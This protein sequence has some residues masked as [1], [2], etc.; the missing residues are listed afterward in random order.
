[1]LGNAIKFTD[2][3]EVVLRVSFLD[4]SP[5]RASLRFDISDT[6]IGIP[7]EA[8]EKIFDPFSQ[9]DGSTTRKYGGTGLGLAICNKLVQLMGGTMGIHSE[10]GKG[11]TFWF[12]ITLEKER[13]ETTGRRK[14]VVSGLKP[15]RVLVVDDN[16]TNREILSY[17]LQGWGLSYELV[18]GGEK[19]LESLRSAMIKGQLFDVV[20]TDYHMPGMDGMEMVRTIRKDP[21]FAGLRLV[22]LSSVSELDAT[23]QWLGA[24]VDAFL[25]KPVRQSELYNCLSAV[26]GDDA[27]R[28][29]VTE[30]RGAAPQVAAQTGYV[31]VAEDNPVNQELVSI[32]LE[33]LGYRADITS[34]GREA[35]N[36]VIR[37]NL[38]DAN[39]DPYD[40]VLMDCQMPDMDG[41]DA[42]AEVRRLEQQHAKERRL[43]IVALTAHVLDSERQ[44]CKLAGM[45][46]YLSKPFSQQQLGEVVAR[47]LSPDVDHQEVGTKV[48]VSG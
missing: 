22:M 10:I 44:R 3:G 38:A 32:M 17:Q 36:A 37:Q 31:L 48:Q 11:S 28:P 27:A 39:A 42:T 30:P 45:D 13:G 19:A 16:A 4:E 33:G 35:L 40:L 20:I 8:L 2:S 23:G 5:E 41:Y 24:G 43:P 25:N 7:P 21:Q 26:L 47:W 46:D 9:A 29:Q 14:P 6:G 18:D 34:T 12:S 1:L 15:A